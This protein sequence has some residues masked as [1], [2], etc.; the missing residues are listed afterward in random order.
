MRFAYRLLRRRPGL[1]PAPYSTDDP[2]TAAYQA[3]RLEILAAAFGGS[4]EEQWM[5]LNRLEIA[6]LQAGRPEDAGAAHI[7]A[8]A[9]PGR[10]GHAAIEQWERSPRWF[11]LITRRFRTQLE[12]RW[13][14]NRYLSAA[15]SIDALLSETARSSS[16]KRVAR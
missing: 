10:H 16:G 7:R 11:K 8:M 5:I 2:V 15:R 4:P 13:T 9:M 1:T 12:L 3:V 6:Y 14:E